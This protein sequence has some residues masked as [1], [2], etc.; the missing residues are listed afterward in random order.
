MSKKEIV[1]LVSR[2]IA[3]LQIAAALVDCVTTLPQQGF[4]LYREAAMFASMTA[5]RRLPQPLTLSPLLWVNLLT[6][7]LR[8]GVLLFIAALFWNCGP[9]VERWLAP[10]GV[11]Q[12]T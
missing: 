5:V 3:L 11:E 8:I 12:E 7:L 6:A 1:L 9:T 4:L 10:A 2:A